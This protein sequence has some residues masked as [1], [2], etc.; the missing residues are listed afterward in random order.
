MAPGATFKALTQGPSLT[1]V[2]QGQQ[3][4]LLAPWTD[5]LLFEV[6]DGQLI[7]PLRTLLGPSVWAEWKRG[8]TRK[9]F[10]ALLIASFTTMGVDGQEMMDLIAVLSNND[11]CRA[12][13]AD[14]SQVGLSLSMLGDGLSMVQLCMMYEH[15]SQD[16]FLARS[17]SELGRDAWD[18]KEHMLADILD[19]L[20]SILQKEHI[21][22]QQRG[23]KKMP[24][25][26]GPV[27]VRPGT[28]K[29]VINSPL[30]LK[31]ML[32]RGRRGNPRPS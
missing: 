23:I 7:G 24:K 15:L 12:V 19:T 28:P 3:F 4:T 31:A 21:A 10:D 17:L 5:S 13:E 1:F 22:V 18:R 8:K 11:H 14:L 9:D 29:K 6:V 16:S 32:E 30:D 27:Y 20:V 2:H 26:P 25:P